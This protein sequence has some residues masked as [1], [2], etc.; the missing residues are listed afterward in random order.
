MPPSA[1][2]GDVSTHG[3]AIIGSGVPTVLIAGM[4]A[5]V[6]TA[7]FIAD[8]E[9]QYQRVVTLSALAPV[10]V[11][12]LDAEMAAKYASIEMGPAV[13]PIEVLGAHSLPELQADWLVAI[14]NGWVENVL[15]K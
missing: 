8:P 5:A 6:V 10:D 13:L 4:P 14:E 9:V 3:G 15:Q 7:N 2:L 1:R 11:S 12:T